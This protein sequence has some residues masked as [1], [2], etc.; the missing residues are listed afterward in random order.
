MVDLRKET[1]G[2]DPL[3]MFEE[4]RTRIRTEM[5]GIKR[6]ERIRAAGLF[7]ARERIERLLDPGSFQEIGTFAA[8][9]R[10]E[11]R[12]NTPGDGRIAGFGRLDG[13]PIGLVADDATVKGASASVVNIRKADR[14]YRQA[15]KAGHPLIFLGET[16]G[17]RI[18]DYL[19]SDG[20]S[21]VSGEAVDWTLRAR[22]I[23]LATVITG[24]SFGGSTF[25]AAMSDL[26]V[27]IRGTCLAVVSPRVIEVATGE[28]TDFETIGGV[29]LHGKITGQVDLV[30]DSED[31]AFAMLR[32]WLSYLPPSCHER[33]PR[34]EPRQPETGTSLAKLVPTE[35]RMP[36]DMRKLL[37]ALLDGGEF[38]EL[39]PDFGRSLITALA[40]IEG[41]TVGII[42]SNPIFGAGAI[43]PAACDKGTRLL[44]LCDAFGLPIVL[45][46]DSPGFM[47]GSR[48]E[49]QKIQSKTVLF[50]QALMQ[51]S[52]PRFSVILRKSYGLSYTSLGG[53]GTNSDL[54]VAW[55]GAEVGF[56]DPAVAANA[57]HGA[58]LSMMEGDARKARARQL[59]TELSSNNEP[60]AA[61][62]TMRIDEIIHPN[63]TR[64]VL[65][66]ALI[67][68]AAGRR[69]DPALRLL[70][71]WPT[72]W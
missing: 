32:R 12:V 52:V 63:E 22:S 53:A 15:L 6:I 29:E 14:V 61:A 41:H 27:Q 48:V 18:P 19:G 30:A 5:G 16:R 36:Y 62:R 13:R 37:P 45:L 40:R 42:A 10:A 9:L 1:S 59:A 68:H 57:I 2:D 39:K 58:E 65:A 72:C 25:V 69:V 26:V 60:Y 46:H 24:P 71:W 44:C 55:P 28:K 8:S 51:C 49:A 31:D 43:D 20:L 11:D 67:R 54:L 3:P 56:M 7:T 50:L 4:R 33:P 23:P 35:R 34:V 64:S 47:V 66:E 17:S 38:L 70:R 21:E